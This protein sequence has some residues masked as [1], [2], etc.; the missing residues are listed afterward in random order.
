MCQ[1]CGF[2]ICQCNQTYNYNWYNTDGL[3]CTTC[4]GTLVCAKKVPAKCT[5]YNGVNMD[6]IGLTTNIDVETILASLNAVLSN[7]QITDQQQGLTNSAILVILNDI[8]TRINTLAG[9]SPHAA[10]TISGVL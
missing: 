2:S 5:I 6:S 9:G 1:T 3:P 7:M 10:Y 4:S 8:N